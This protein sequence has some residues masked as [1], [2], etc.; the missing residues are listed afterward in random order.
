[1]H[2]IVKDKSAKRFILEKMMGSLLLLTK[3][4]AHD[5]DGASAASVIE[6]SSY[7]C[8]HVPHCCIIDLT[9]YA[10]SL[11]GNPPSF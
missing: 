1:M 10:I 8:T 2:F 3:D 6:S 5:D 11:A 7:C 9:A 4:V